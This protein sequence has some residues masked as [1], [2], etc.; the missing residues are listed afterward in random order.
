[1]QTA[2]QPRTAR[3]QDGADPATTANPT[4]RYPDRL[5]LRGG[6]LWDIARAKLYFLSGAGLIKIGV[7]TDV[8]ARW[9]SLRNS[10]PVALDFLGFC[11]GTQIDEREF[12]DRFKHIRRHGE[13]FDDTPELR[14]AIRIAVN[15]DGGLDGEW[16]VTDC[17][18]GERA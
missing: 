3:E 11:P 4:R 1:M 16:A 18:K 10:S 15:V 12:H 6:G 9:R 7:T 13:W 5:K 2:N 17:L 14:E 8:D